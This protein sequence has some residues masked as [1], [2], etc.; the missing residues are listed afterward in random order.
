MRAFHIELF[1]LEHSPAAT[2]GGLALQPVWWSMAAVGGPDQCEIEAAG[3][4]LALWE[5]LRWLRWGVQVINPYGTRVWWGYVHEVDVALGPGLRI[6]LSL[7][8][9]YNRVAVA[10]TYEDGA[11]SL[12]RAVT[13]W[14]EHA[15]SMDRYGARELRFT[16][17]D[18]NAELAE[19]TQ[20][21]LL[22]QL[23]VPRGSPSPM[24]DS[25]GATLRCR[26]WWQTLGWQYY[27]QTAGKEGFE[28]VGGANQTVGVGTGSASTVIGFRAD[29]RRIFNT[30]TGLLPGSQFVVS[31][32]GSNDGLFTVQT[33]NTQPDATITDT[34]IS[35]SEEAGSADD[36]I[37]DSNSGLGSLLADDVVQVE[38][39]SSNDGIYTVKTE[40]AA[41]LE[42]QESELVYEAAGGSVTLRRRSYV[43]VKQNVAEEDAGAS[44]SITAVGVEVAQ[45]F[46][47]EIDASWT[48]AEIALR[49]K[50]VGSPTDNLKVALHANNAGSPGAE[51]DSGTIAGSDLSPNMGWVTVSLNNTDAL[52]YGTTYWVV[53]SRTGTRS[54]LNY[55]MVD[56]DED[57]SYS[58]GGLK[59]YN[60]SSWTTRATDADMPFVIWGQQETSSQL[61]TL[62]GTGEL[63]AGA[64][65]VDASGVYSRQWRDGES[66]ALDEARDLLA[67][68]TSSG[69]RLLAEVRPSRE[70]RIYAA[71]DANVSY[72]WTAYADG[73]WRGPRDAAVE[74]GMLP[75]GRWMRLGD[76]PGQ[77]DAIAS[78][79]PVY[80]ERATYRA[81][82][83]EMR[84]EPEGA[85]DPWSVGEVVQG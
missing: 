63:L 47:Q 3:T 27:A 37:Y 45:S 69:G 19:A 29:N 44:V 64:D 16:R 65:V 42:V 72:D 46:T 71:A 10:Y 14:A 78:L 26:G 75:A 28:Q 22:R 2:P 39:T 76:I 20:A 12:Q 56:V 68:G 33:L 67:A 53:V 24:G 73:R 34:T 62:I 32:S 83:G 1:N 21:E 84:W 51:L 13:D 82:T 81:A 60:G 31:G 17:S 49:V 70:V 9:L 79:S 58:G 80:I 77:I 74:P 30:N 15:A 48:V 59:L 85:P 40:D 57:L 18:T 11:G 4:H 23:G 7:E 6:T 43:T 8:N 61:E 55:Y 41:N 50:R 35:F 25:A 38:G 5:T 54:L 36:D 66:L 52:S